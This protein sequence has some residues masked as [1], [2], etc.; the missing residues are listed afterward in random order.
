M[1]C[2]VYIGIHVY[3]YHISNLFLLFEGLTQGSLLQLVHTLV[4][5]FLYDRY[6]TYVYYIVCK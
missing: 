1:S 2:V 6:S 4:L 5:T 3:Y